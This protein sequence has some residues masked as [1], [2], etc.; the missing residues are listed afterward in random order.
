MSVDTPPALSQTEVTAEAERNVLGAIMLSAGEV[1]DYLNLDS[2]DYASP[3]H[4]AIHDAAVALKARGVPPDQMT[5]SDQLARMQVRISTTY[6]HELASLTATPSSAEHYAAIV[7]EHASRRRAMEAA[8]Q[9]R[10]MVE[11]HTDPAVIQ[12]QAQAALDGITPAA[13]LDPVRFAAETLTET[14]SDLETQ[15]AYMPTPWPSLDDIIGGLQP[16]ALYTIG[17]RPGVGKTVAGVQLAMAMAQ[18]GS[19][20]IISLEMSTTELHMRMISSTGKIPFQKLRD[21]DLDDDTWDK[22]AAVRPRIEA[23]P[24]AI[25][26]RSSVTIGEIRRYVTATARAR[27]PLAGVVIDYL[28]LINS[29]PGDKR[30]R[31]EYIAALTRELK[32]LAKDHQVPVVLLSQLNRGSTQRD[33]KQPQLADL[34]ESGA[35]EQ[36]SDVVILLHRLIDDPAAMHEIEMRVAKNRHGRPGRT[37]LDFWGHYSTIR[38]TT[39]RAP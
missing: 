14:I 2:S 35:I 38:D 1:L 27:K 39:R 16:G 36:D 26:D 21:R 15:R 20:P 5:I 11:S 9:I 22:I 37:T 3:Q 32:T 31:H 23:L 29:P 28:Q 34:R 24:T 17:A 13:T 25:L 18:H 8:T 33:D 4:E 7:A 19:V 12:E 30:P 6:L 10:L